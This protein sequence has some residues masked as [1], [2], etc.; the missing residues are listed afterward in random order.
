MTHQG[1]QQAGPE[2][3]DDEAVATVVGH[4]RDQ[5][6]AMLTTVAADGSLLARPMTLQQVDA[7]GDAWLFAS[8]ETDTVADLQVDDRVNL[9]FSSSDA[10]VSVAGRVEVRR[11]VVRARDLWSRPAEAWFDSPDDPDLRVLHVQAE[12]AQYWDS[13]G[14]AATVV[15]MLR[16]SFSDDTPDV[17]ES[18][19]VDLPG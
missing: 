17:G 9:A 7:T 14:R 6:I 8:A 5:R 16:A 10:W 1:E 18:D 11:D 3:V 19:Q 15:A 13:P 12:S 4:M 2:R